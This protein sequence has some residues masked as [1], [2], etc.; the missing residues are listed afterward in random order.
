MIHS[1]RFA[2]GAIKKERE[3]TGNP[4]MILPH[5]SPLIA[6]TT[7]HTNKLICFWIQKIGISDE[8]CTNCSTV[9]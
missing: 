7:T 2:G 4:Q 6:E 1:G 8:N 5:R 9:D 3:T